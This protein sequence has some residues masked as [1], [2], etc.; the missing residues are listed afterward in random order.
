MHLQNIITFGL[1]VAVC[2][3]SS[4]PDGWTLFGEKC[5]FYSGSETANWDAAQASCYAVE[6]QLVEIESSA[7][8][9]FLVELRSNFSSNSSESWIGLIDRENE[10][11]HV[12]DSTGIEASYPSYQSWAA[13][14]PNGEACIQ[15]DSN[16]YWYDADCNLE[17]TYFCERLVKAKCPSGWT[18]FRGHCYKYSREVRKVWEEAEAACVADKGHLVDINSVGENKFLVNLMNAVYVYISDAWIGLNDR[19]INDTYVWVS[20]GQNATYTNWG[21]YEPNDVVWTQACVLMDKRKGQWNDRRCSY[22]RAYICKKASCPYGWTLF[23]ESCYLYSGDEKKSWDAAQSACF[24]AE[25]QLVEIESDSENNFIVEL[26][27][28]V[29]SN[30]T[31]SWIGLHDIETEGKHIWVSSGN[32]TTYSSWGSGEPNDH[33]GGACVQLHGNGKWNDTDCQLERSYVCE[34]LVYVK[35]PKG[36]IFFR[37]ECYKHDREDK[38]DWE[39]AEAACVADYSHLVDIN[40]D[41]E[42]KFLTNLMRADYK[43]P[44]DAWIGLNDREVNDTYVWVSSGKVAVYTSWG[45]YE[46]NDVVWTQACVQMNWRG[47]WDDKRCSYARA[48]I[49]KRPAKAKCPERWTFFRNDCYKYN[50]EVKKPW[51]EAEDACVADAGHLVDINSRDENTFLTYLMT[52]DILYP[53]DTWIGLNDREINDTHVWVSSGKV[54]TYT[55]WGQYEPNDVVWTQAC[56]LMTSRGEWDDKRCTYSRAYICKRPPREVCE[57]GFK[58]L[59]R[60]CYKYFHNTSSIDW[61]SAQAVCMSNGGHLAEITSAEINTFL[62]D[63]REEDI[64]SHTAWIGLKL[65]GGTYKWIASGKTATFKN[66]ATGEPNN[67]QSSENCIEMYPDGKWNDHSCANNRRYFCEKLPIILPYE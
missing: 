31:E 38:R 46:P 14:E 13:N 1:I 19:E 8:K 2:S 36:W 23:G 56:V 52:R 25:G 27:T 48:Y 35:C 40:S 21:Q 24:N 66:W 20:S 28:N 6:G 22:S 9:A 12:W 29:S 54:A 10:G 41:A 58:L 17:R 26:K 42:I 43:Y 16:S 61:E 60:R 30:P 50:S 57:S 59:D 18:F 67:H 55:S 64:G 3:L 37:G 15:M 53:S 44:F 47:K 63:L 39:Q 49:C 62:S 5:Y 33:D 32:N 51:E 4:C 7:E 34:R 65:V 45:Q 11:K